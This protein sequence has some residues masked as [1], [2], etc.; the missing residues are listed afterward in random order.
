M[1]TP[2]AVVVGM[3]GAGKS[4]VGAGVAE[5]LGLPFADADTLI[6]AKAGKTVPEIF[7]DEGEPAFRELEK[8]TIADALTSFDGV[9]ALG[10]GSILDAETRA[11]LAGATVVHLSVQLPD[12]IKRVGM[13]AGRPL[14]N[15]NPRAAL[16][17]LMDQRRPLYEEVAT[18]T[19]V[20]DGRDPEDIADEVAGLLKG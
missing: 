3:P 1:S 10:G 12:A 8:T 4:T 19:V 6:E 17:H 5:R 11:A 20:T 18:Y 14:L 9:L 13:G 16:R 2:V 7:F 15:I